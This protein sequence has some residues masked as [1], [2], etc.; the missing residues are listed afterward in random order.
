MPTDSPPSWELYWDPQAS[1]SLEG[2]LGSQVPGV[3]LQLSSSY[4]FSEETEGPVG[5]RH[6]SNLYI[7]SSPNTPHTGT[8]DPKTPCPNPLGLFQDLYNLSRVDLQKADG[9]VIVYSLMS[10]KAKK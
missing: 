10:K 2:L 9:T 8:C 3:F 1:Q 6:V 4:D 5:P 7:L